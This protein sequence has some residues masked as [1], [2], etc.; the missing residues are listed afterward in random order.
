[1]ALLPALMAWVMAYKK[2]K[3]PLVAYGVV[4]FIA[5][6]IFFTLRYLS[7]AADLPQK[8]VQKQA[9]FLSLQKARSFI[10]ITLLLPTLKSFITNAPQATGHVL[11]RPYITDYRLS[12]YLLPFAIELFFYQIL[13]ITFLF[14]RNKTL[15]VDPFILFCLFFSFS[16]LLITGYTVPVMYAIIRYRSVYLPLLLAPL[17]CNINWEKLKAFIYIK[18]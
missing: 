1:M 17:L 11:L 9:D 14:F 10:D 3:Y 16:V 15:A 13:F 8:I 2:K 5:V 12:F 4:Y 6:V 18:K 7:P